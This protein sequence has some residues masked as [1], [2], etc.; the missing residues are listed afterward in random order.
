MNTAIRNIEDWNDTFAREHDIDEYYNNASPVIRFIEQSRLACIRRMVAAT[1]S[2]NILELGCGGGHVL[3]QFPQSSLTGVDV[4]GEML[5]KARTNLQGYQ[6]TLLKGELH[7]LDLPQHSFDAVICT[8]V[9]EHVLNPQMILQGLQRLLKPSGR[10]VI[11]FPNDL[12]INRIKNTIRTARLTHLPVFRRISWGGDDYHIHVWSKQ[13][14]HEL[15]AKYFHVAEYAPAP[16]RMFPIRCC[17][18]CLAQ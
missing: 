17:F 4:S 7:E 13:Q 8:E 3:R 15:L 11:T 14:M 1:P 5:R 2:D 10:A 6:A 9:L 16:H 18:K 12:L